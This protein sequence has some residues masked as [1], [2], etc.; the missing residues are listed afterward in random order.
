MLF[1][2][3][4]FADRA[5]RRVFQQ[6]YELQQM[7][8]SIA[9][10]ILVIPLAKITTTPTAQSRCASSKPILWPLVE[11][12]DRTSRG[13]CLKDDSTANIARGRG[14]ACE[15][16][17]V[18]PYIDPGAGIGHGDGWNNFIEP[19]AGCARSPVDAMPSSSVDGSI[20]SLRDAVVDPVCS[21]SP[22]RF[23]RSEPGP[24]LDGTASG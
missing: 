10:R 6:A 5:F 9:D 13:N 20:L 14:H 23:E 8:A 7:L 24:Q 19:P 17:G 21:S 3:G 1:R 18:T 11:T 22:M 12:Q 4:I 15:A 2:R 16:I